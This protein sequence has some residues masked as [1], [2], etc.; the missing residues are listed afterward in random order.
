MRRKLWIWSHLLEKSLMENLF[1]VQCI[2]KVLHDQTMNY[3]TE[4]NI[5]YRYQS[6]FR[7]NHSTGTSLSYLREK[8]LIGFDPGLL[9][10]IILIN[11]QKKTFD[12]INHGILLKKMSALR[13]SDRSKNWFKSYISNRSFRVNVKGK[14]SCIAKIDCGVSQGSIYV[15]STLCER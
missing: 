4:N 7:Q 9:T 12:T 1:F 2:G 11:L 15:V 10:G 13:F 8:I 5:L 6:R 3:L 14:Y